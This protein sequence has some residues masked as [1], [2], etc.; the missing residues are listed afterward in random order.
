MDG[1]AGGR[2]CHNAPPVTINNRVSACRRL[3]FLYLTGT[4]KLGRSLRVPE[5]VQLKASR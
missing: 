3:L 1:F 2:L 5:D 4:P